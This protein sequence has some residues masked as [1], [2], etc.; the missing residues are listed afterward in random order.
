MNQ[1]MVKKD[2]LL[3]LS[4]CSVQFHSKLSKGSAYVKGKLLHTVT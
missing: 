3:K 2:D 4:L 1:Q